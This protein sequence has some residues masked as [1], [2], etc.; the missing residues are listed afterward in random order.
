MTTIV[1]ITS[2]VAVGGNHSTV[3]EGE[4]SIVAV[5]VGS[6][7]DVGSGKQAARQITNRMIEIFFINFLALNNLS[8]LWANGNNF[9]W[10]VN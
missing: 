9:C 1:A 10:Y 4:G 8:S 5:A 3:E 2:R 6:C 7:V